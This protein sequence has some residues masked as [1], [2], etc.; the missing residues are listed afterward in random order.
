MQKHQDTG[1]KPKLKKANTEYL[2]KSSQVVDK[3]ATTGARERLHK[4]TQ[5]LRTG[6]KPTGTSK[7]LKKR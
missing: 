6:S 7:A 1:S 2:R 4:A 5:M 3:R